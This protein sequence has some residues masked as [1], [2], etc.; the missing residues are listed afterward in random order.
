MPHSSVEIEQNSTAAA[1][2]QG[3]QRSDLLI[4]MPSTTAHTPAP[5]KRPPASSPSPR[6]L[7]ISAYALH[8]S[9]NDAPRTIG[10]AALL[11]YSEA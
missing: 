9:A 3:T 1:L 7:S 11:Q 4:K 10:A 2:T 5:P 8:R 6:I